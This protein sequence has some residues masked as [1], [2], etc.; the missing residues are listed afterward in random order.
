LFFW[1][2]HKNLDDAFDFVLRR[3]NR[4]ELAFLASSVKSRPTI[5][6][7]GFDLVFPD[8]LFLVD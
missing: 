4:I 1:R 8:C 6:R 2:R 5:E 3:F 7:W